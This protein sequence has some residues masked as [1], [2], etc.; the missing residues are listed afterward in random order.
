L[1]IPQVLLELS[2]LPVSPPPPTTFECETSQRNPKT[3][4][5]PKSQQIDK[6]KF[7]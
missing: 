3:R 4:L 5:F 2:F 1:Q 6:E 7:E